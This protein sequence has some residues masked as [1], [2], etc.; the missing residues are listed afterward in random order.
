MC[1]G[2][3]G[4]VRAMCGAFWEA[5]IPSNPGTKALD[6]KPESLNPEALN[7]NPKPKSPKPNPQTLF[8]PRPSE[9]APGPSSRL[10]GQ[11]R[12]TRGAS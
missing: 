1:G 4:D 2:C 12:G 10:K 7:P 5:A 11:V 6:R 3:A 8:Q 9:S